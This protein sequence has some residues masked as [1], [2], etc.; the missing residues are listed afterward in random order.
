MSSVAIF[1][2]SL[3][4]WSLVPGDLLSGNGAAVLHGRAQPPVRGRAS[5]PRGRCR[6][7][8]DRYLESDAACRGRREKKRASTSWTTFVGETPVPFT[9][10]YSPSPSLGGYSEL[11]VR[12]HLA[13]GGGPGHDAAAGPMGDRAISQ[14]CRRTCAQLSDRPAREQAGADSHLGNRL[15]PRVRHRRPG[16]E[17][18]GE[19]PGTRNI[20]DDWGRPRKEA[21]GAHRRGASAP[22]GRDQPGGRARPADLL[23]RSRDHSLPRG[24]REHSRARSKSSAADRRDLDRVQN[25]SV[26]S[27]AAATGSVPLSQVADIDLEWQPSAILRR[28]RYRTVTVQADVDEGTTAIAVIQAITPV[29]RRAVRGAGRSAI[30]TSSAARSSRA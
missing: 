25:L 9:L 12:H 30:A 11:M 7:E 8:V 18:L 6:A 1:F 3:Q 10:G 16:R 22:S 26:F 15:R 24:R 21:R 17:Q 29:A 4:L 28:D 23:E 19:I 13:G 14:T 27:K 5:R 2:G 20:D